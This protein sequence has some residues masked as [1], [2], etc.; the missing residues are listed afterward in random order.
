M[1]GI[2]FLALMVATGSVPAVSR[3]CGFDF[4]PGF[5]GHGFAPYMSDLERQTIREQA[6]AD[7]RQAFLARYKLDA[8]PSA[9]DTTPAASDQASIQAEPQATPNDLH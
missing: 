5:R 3:A 4:M 9:T 7:A 8:E 2:V 1:R 6:I